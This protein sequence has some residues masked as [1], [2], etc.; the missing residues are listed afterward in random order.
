MG[1]NLV[2]AAKAR[3]HKVTWVDC[4]NDAETARALEEKLMKELPRHDALIM[5]AAVCD[6]RP[7]A[8]SAS[9][10]KKTGLSR[11]EV[12]PNP[13]ILAG[14]AKKKRKNQIFFGFAIESQNILKAGAEKLRKKG[15]DAIFIQKVNSKEAPFGD[16]KISAFLLR[17][18]EANVAIKN[19]PKRKIA[20]LIIKEVERLAK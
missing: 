1:K 15:L 4:P 7:R 11:I 9:K 17:R 3:R 12:V 18:G 16:K 5:A 10:I 19:Q 8:F 14:L 20:G 2:A 13:D 6:V